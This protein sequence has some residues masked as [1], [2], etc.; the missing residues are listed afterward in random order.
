MVY[1]VKHK[2]LFDWNDSPEGEGFV[3]ISLFWEL[4]IIHLITTIHWIK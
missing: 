1:K 3:R 4:L 2:T